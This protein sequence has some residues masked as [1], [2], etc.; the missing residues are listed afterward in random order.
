MSLKFTFVAV[1]KFK[2]H[3]YCYIDNQEMLTEDCF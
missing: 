3:W 1:Q 2:G